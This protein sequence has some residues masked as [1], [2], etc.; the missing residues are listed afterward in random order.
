[1]PWVWHACRQAVVYL[2]RAQISDADAGEAE[3]IWALRAGSPNAHCLQRAAARQQ[4]PSCTKCQTPKGAA[5]R[6]ASAET[7]KQKEATICRCRYRAQREPGAPGPLNVERAAV[8][9]RDAGQ[10]PVAS[11]DARLDPAASRDPGGCTLHTPT[12]TTDGGRAS[13][14]PRNSQQR[15]RSRF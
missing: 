8:D 2:S 9:M 5:R 6:S 4:R 11:R 12:T 7:Q 1:M 15:N 14:W 13:Y 10:R 3:P